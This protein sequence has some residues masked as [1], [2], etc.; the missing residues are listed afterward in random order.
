VYGQRPEPKTL[1]PL[2]AN[3]GPSRE[4]INRM[5]ADLVHINRG[6]LKTELALAKS[7]K[8]SADG[9]RYEIELRQG[10]RFSDGQ[11]FDADDVVFTFQVYLDPKV[12]SPQ[13]SF[14]ILDGKPVTVRKLGP[15]RVSF[16]L[17]RLNAA[18]ERIFDGV[19]MLPRHLLET[20]YR[21]GKIRDVWGL[22]TP[23]AQIAGLGPFRLK[24]Y[25]PGQRIV[26]ERNPYYWKTDA[27]KTRLPYLAELAFTFAASEDMQV[28]RFQSGESDAIARITPKDY[29]VLQREA[30]RRGYVMQDVGPGLEYSF[31]CFN[32]NSAARQKVWGRA[33]FRRAVSAA[34]D[35]AAIVKL[36]YQGF[37]VPLAAPV[38]AGNRQWVN[39]AIANSPRSLESAR[40]LLTADGFHWSREGAL[41][42]PAGK[43]VEF[44][45]LA[46][47]SNPER[48][49]MATLIQADLKPLGIRVNVVQLEFR[50]LIDRVTGSREFD[51]A[52]IALA[53]TDA[54]PNADLNLW[55]SS[56]NQ[57]VWNVSQTTP[58]TPWETEIDGL[59]RKQLITRPYATR[60]RI[61]DRVQQLGFDNTAVV[62]LVTPHLLVG[63]KKDLGNFRP[64]LLEPYVLWN[65]DELYWKKAGAGTRR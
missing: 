64:A 24:E 65:A 25:A 16:E 62:P 51:A 31:L 43:P 49:Q 18:G 2:I 46:S 63:A 38:G 41:L 13:R 44:S 61:F 37:A 60:K 54:D 53:S 7:Y 56:G 15:Y 57:H 14:W 10:L 59:M 48:V 27:D 22:R 19:P 47:S 34:I 21:E 55:L 35:R 8:V 20:A 23:P 52:I 12:N 5:M 33:A 9:L 32:L 26:L 11:P 1:N 28:L 39:Q 4:V 30:E 3:D 45:I 6:N 29:A 42:D 50:T 40:A 36:A 17:P 58:A